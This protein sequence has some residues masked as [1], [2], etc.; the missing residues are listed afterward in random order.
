MDLLFIVIGI[1][2]LFATI[3]IIEEILR[4]KERKNTKESNETDLIKVA[5]ERNNRKKDLQFNIG[6]QLMPI[7]AW[8]ITEII[9]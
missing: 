7:I 2:I 6:L 4:K 9:Y 5:V 1:E 3:W 8:I